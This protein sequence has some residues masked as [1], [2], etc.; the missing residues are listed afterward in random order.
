MFNT[1]ILYKKD[2]SPLEKVT[3]RELHEVYFTEEGYGVKWTSDSEMNIVNDTPLITGE[4]MI[5]LSKRQLNLFWT[6]IRNTTIDLRE[7]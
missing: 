3:N 2:S 4:K 1:D 6:I 7:L 5:N